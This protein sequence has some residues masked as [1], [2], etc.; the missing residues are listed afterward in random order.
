VEAY[1]DNKISQEAYISQLKEMLG[2]TI[3]NAEA[4]KILDDTLMNYYGD[5][6]AAAGEELAKFTSQME[7]QSSVLDHYKSIMTAI[8]KEVDY[9]RMGVIL[10][11]QSELLGDQYGIAKQNYEMLAGET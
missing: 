2:A 11:G 10:K 7:H 8:G 9:K 4:L 5:T 3:A 6:L 1:R